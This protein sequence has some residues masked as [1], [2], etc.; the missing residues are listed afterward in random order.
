MK[1]H[2]M[3]GFFPFLLAVVEEGMIFYFNVVNIFIFIRLEI[4]V[5]IIPYKGILQPSWLI[6]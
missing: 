6:F 4:V 2:Q 3:D 1:T 5:R